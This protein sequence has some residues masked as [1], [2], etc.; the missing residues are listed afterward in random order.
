MDVGEAVAD[1]PRIGTGEEE[2]RAEPEVGE[3]VSVRRGDALDEPVQAEAS[4]VVG[5]AARGDVAGL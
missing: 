3:P 4:E 2:R 5:H 1:D